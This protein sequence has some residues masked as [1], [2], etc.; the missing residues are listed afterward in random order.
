MSI[1]D[2]LII[3]YYHGSSILL[4][5]LGVAGCVD[6]DV[7]LAG[8]PNDFEGRVEYCAGGTW[9][10]VCGSGAW[11]RVPGSVV[12]NHTANCECIAMHTAA[13]HRP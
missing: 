10:Q 12:C 1:I 5:I 8:G 13:A 3:Y 2:M 9:A 4:I 11:G 6:G 7:Q